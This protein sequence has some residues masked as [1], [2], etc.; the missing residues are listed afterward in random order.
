MSL[1]KQIT[2]IICSKPVLFGKLCTI[3]S[4]ILFSCGVIK[5]S[6][7]TRREHFQA[8]LDQELQ[9]DSFN[10]LSETQKVLCLA[11]IIPCIF[12]M[13]TRET[14]ELQKKSKE[15]LPSTCV[16]EKQDFLYSKERVQEFLEKKE[17]LLETVLQESDIVGFF[18][19]KL[20]LGDMLYITKHLPTE[21]TWNDL[22][23]EQQSMILLQ[24]NLYWY[25]NPSLVSFSEPVYS[26]LPSTS[27]GMNEMEKLKEKMKDF[28]PWAGPYSQEN[29][30]LS[31]WKQ[32]A[33][34]KI[35][36]YKDM[37]ELLPFQM[38]NDFDS[39]KIIFK[40]KEV[41]TNSIEE[42]ILQKCYSSQF[43]KTFSILPDKNSFPVLY[44]SLEEFAEKANDDEILAVMFQL[45]WTVA[46]LQLLFPG[47]Q[48]N[49]INQATVLVKFPKHRCYRVSSS[50]FIFNISADFP[51]PV[52]TT[53]DTCTSTANGSRIP[54]SKAF[55]SKRDILE[56]CQIF[57]KSKVG[58]E[59]V[60][61][62]EENNIQNVLFH[63]IFDL[64]LTKQGAKSLSIAMIEN[65]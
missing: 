54:T 22:T 3:S 38:T 57:Q 25:K 61:I 6:F 65:L 48:H 34:N 36:T 2:S 42:E 16:I 12:T 37:M 45:L 23:E 58:K 60:Q 35:M 11:V 44:E 17:F 47:F 32:K 55:D 20:S 4:K 46:I 8:F 7:P 29:L 62:C 41:V 31:L 53:F 1:Q 59:M 27:K 39:V 64:F 26:Y 63:E 50:S 56:I 18:K 10:E 33:T 30:S 49:A 40:E 52:L 5:D 9:P 15:F 13:Q 43:P 21:F 19:D 51:L 28:E 14:I 24:Q